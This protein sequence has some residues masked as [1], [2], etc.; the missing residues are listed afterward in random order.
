MFSESGSSSFCF[1]GVSSNSKVFLSDKDL[2]GVINNMDP[3]VH[4]E[5]CQ[6]LIQ[7]DH[8]LIR[9]KQL[10]VQQEEEEEEEK[11]QR[12][13]NIILTTKPVCPINLKLEIPS[14]SYVGSENDDDGLKTPTSS[15]HKIPV[16]LECPCAPKKTK[17]KPAGTKRKSCRPRIVL[18]LYN[19]LESLF[20]VP[21]GVDLGGGVMNK[22]VKQ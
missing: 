15:D 1:M 20:P 10:S 14:S 18:D 13:S 6:T 5:G 4:K 2:K 12:N 7:E 8:Q 21:Y 19:D 3:L 11:Q 9:L 22:R 16:I 17:S